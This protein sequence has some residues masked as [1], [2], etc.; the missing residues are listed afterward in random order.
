MLDVL[1]FNYHI[2]LELYLDFT[3]ESSLLLEHP[4]QSL[5]FTPSHLLIFTGMHISSHYDL[6]VYKLQSPL[7]L[8]MEELSKELHDLTLNKDIIS[9]LPDNI[10]DM[11]L[12][13]LPLEEAMS[14]SLLSRYWRYK[15]RSMSEIIIDDNQYTSNNME[16][17]VIHF[18]LLHKGNI[19][20][21]EYT[22]KDAFYS[23]IYIYGFI[24]WSVLVFNNL[25]WT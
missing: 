17:I 23:Y 11:I 18:L 12:A 4:H 3:W 22:G 16:K 20:K 5:F 10:I 7:F 9:F 2:Y 14:T 6:F 15:R 25:N 19:E 21:F 24:I 13:R 1:L 8:Q